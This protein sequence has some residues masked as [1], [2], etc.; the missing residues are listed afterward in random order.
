MYYNMFRKYECH[1]VSDANHLCF[2]LVFI[3]LFKI[4]WFGL[5]DFFFVLF[6][7]LN[8]DAR[9]A[10]SWISDT[11]LMDTMI[12]KAVKHMFGTE[13]GSK[14]EW[15]GWSWHGHLP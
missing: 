12:G 10:T 8:A 7:L 11:H 3:F 14:D 5:K 6:W 13:G 2:C 1:L 15:R 4:Q 9:V